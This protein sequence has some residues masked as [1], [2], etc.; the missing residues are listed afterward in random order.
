MSDQ[1]QQYTPPDPRQVAVQRTSLKYQRAAQVAADV[2]YA[3]FNRLATK[4][5][6]MEQAAALTMNAV[7][8]I[9][10]AVLAVDD[11]LY[12]GEEE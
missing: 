5:L 6:L 12:P 11:I 3:M 10:Q 7:P 4:N 2:V 8:A 9:M 1:S